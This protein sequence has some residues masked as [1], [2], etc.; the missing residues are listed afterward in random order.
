MRY[1]LTLRDELLHNLSHTESELSRLE[2]AVQIL[3]P[4][5]RCRFT[6]LRQCA[7]MDALPLVKRSSAIAFA[8]AMTALEGLAA[9]K[10][11]E[12][13]LAS[14]VEGKLSFKDIYLPALQLYRVL[15]SDNY[16]A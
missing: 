14:W 9:R 8:E 2:Q 1:Q 10:E 4:K 7:D 11:T 13:Q 6:Y 5:L 15:E 16:E 3:D 12:Q